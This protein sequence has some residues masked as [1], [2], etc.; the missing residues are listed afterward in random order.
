MIVHGS[1]LLRIAPRPNSAQ[2]LAAYPGL[3]DMQSQGTKTI[4]HMKSYISML[5]FT[6]VPAWIILYCFTAGV[7]LIAYPANFF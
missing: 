4:V 1:F 5:D 3:N 7:V 2:K 6:S